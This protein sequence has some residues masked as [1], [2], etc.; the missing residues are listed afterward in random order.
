M[1]LVRF[2][3]RDPGGANVLAGFLSRQAGGLSF[4]IWTLP[5][6]TPVFE[7]AGFR[8]RE[9]SENFEPVIVREAWLQLPVHKLI[10]GTSHYAAFEPLLWDLARASG[11]ASLAI[12]DAWANLPARFQAGR[13]D[14]VGA[15]EEGQRSELEALGF[16]PE[17]IIVTGHPWLG[18][19]LENRRQN[20]AA[21]EPPPRRATV[22]ALF[23]S[24]CIASDV[25]Q[26]VNAPFGFDEFDAFA[27]LH[28][29]AMQAAHAGISVELAIK[30]HPYEDPAPFKSRLRGLPSAPGLVV[31]TLDRSA[32]PYPW[33]LWADLVAGIGS[34][35]LLEA[36]V[37]GRPVISVQPGLMREDTF[38]ASRRGFARTLTHPET[39][40][41]ELTHLLT[42]A[43]SRKTVR[44][45]NQGFLQT[46]PC[47]PYGAIREWISRPG[48]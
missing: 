7:S 35:L 26:G 12:N 24:E 6:A 48:N 23:V 46:L 19:L 25:A 17:Q 18:S 27:V 8:C 22:Q 37:L 20:L 36:M 41:Q 3:A 42:S 40:V 44:A 32:K 38:I 47:D 21:N 39:A 13:P 10:T 29:A 30:F 9:F 34:M 28:R 2:A 14:F 15:L 16:R 33:I 4:D 1:A 43:E 5:K 11:C 45:C 31:T